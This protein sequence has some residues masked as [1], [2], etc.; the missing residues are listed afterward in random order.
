M[1]VV[2]IEIKSVYGK[3]TYY[4]ANE[5]ARLFAAIAETKTLSKGDLRK[6]KALGFAVEYVNAYAAAEV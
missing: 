1:Q 4:P 6:I 2:Q 5:A 3:P